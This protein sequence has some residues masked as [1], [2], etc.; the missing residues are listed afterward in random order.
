MNIH[1][2]DFYTFWLNQ[3]TNLPNY[4][5]VRCWRWR[6]TFRS[7]FASKK[8][9]F[10]EKWARINCEFTITATATERVVGLIP[11]FEAQINYTNSAKVRSWRPLKSLKF[12]LPIVGDFF[13]CGFGF[14]R[15]KYSSDRQPNGLFTDQ[16]SHAEKS[17]RKKI[18]CQQE[19]KLSTT[20]HNSH[21]AQK[22]ANW[23]PEKRGEDD[24]GVC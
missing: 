17:N 21:K 5:F 2:G 19:I 6:Q 3:N 20:A 4:A 8:K 1:G 23:D 13:N 10:A 14:N 12:T 16:N 7:F 9:T 11:K 22:N 15:H 24:T 18:S